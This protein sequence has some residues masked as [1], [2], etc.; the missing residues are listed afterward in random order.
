MMS[1]V[2]RMGVNM[3]GGFGLRKYG[4]LNKIFVFF[5][6]RAKSEVFSFNGINIYQDQVN[7]IGFDVF[8]EST[9]DAFLDV[10]KPGMMVLDI[11][12]DVGFYSLLA[13]KQ[14]ATVYAFEPNKNSLE[15]FKESLKDNNLNASVHIYRNA[16]S[17]KKESVELH[18]AG[19][20][21]TV[22]YT[23]IKGTKTSTVQSITIDSLRITPDVV[24]IDTEGSEVK[25]LRGM[26]ETLLRS[27]RLVLFIEFYP[28]LL[29]KNNCTTEEFFDLLEGRL[30]YDLT[31]KRYYTPKELIDRYPAVQNNITNLLVVNT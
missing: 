21:T 17:D 4:V 27:P 20:Q 26:K 13:A 7:G 22:G 25:V 24:K 16:V 30:F 31:E 23:W 28:Y 3:F 1:I 10:V 11:G 18:E 15:F 8:E 2:Y 9:R 14:G 19:P 29:E 5:S 12:A 6:K